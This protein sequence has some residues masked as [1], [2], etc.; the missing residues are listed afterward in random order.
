MNKL[1][2]IVLFIVTY[3]GVFAAGYIDFPRSLTGTQVDIL[4]ALMVYCGLRTGVGLIT[5]EAVLGGLLFDTLSANATGI[6]ILPLFLVGMVLH[7][8]RDLVLRD[9]IYAQSVLGA[10]ASVM[11]PVLSLL[12]LLGLGHKPLVGWGTLWQL[13]VMAIAGGLMTPACFW[14]LDRIERTFG[15]QPMPES[16]FRADRQ[17]IRGRG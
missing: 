14:F 9:Q 8:K 4:P 7:Q 15:Y 5:T 16:S 12:L 1:S 6:T 11:V 17:I 2:V 3:L 13:G 10:A